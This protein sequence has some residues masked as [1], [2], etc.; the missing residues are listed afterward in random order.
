MPHRPSRSLSCYLVDVSGLFFFVEGGLFLSY[1]FGLW[2]CL[3]VIFS[4]LLLEDKFVVLNLNCD[5][6]F[7]L[8]SF[9]FSLC[10]FMFL[11]S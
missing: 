1:I 5:C 9:F 4:H 7:V 8:S 6:L 10:L 11:I 2:S 3:V